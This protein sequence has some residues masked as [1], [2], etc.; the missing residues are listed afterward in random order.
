MHLGKMYPR[1][2]DG[3]FLEGRLLGSITSAP[4]LINEDI[5]K[6]TGGVSHTVH[7][8]RKA[9][10]LSADADVF[11]YREINVIYHINTK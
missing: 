11:K 10:G 4:S 3:D 5:E 7:L 9:R 6:Y 2:A 8:D 1:K